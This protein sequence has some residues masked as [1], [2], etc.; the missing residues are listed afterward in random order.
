VIRDGY[1]ARWHGTDYDAVPGVDGEV[2][3]YA[4]TP[5]DGF[6]E[7]RPGRYVRIVPDH[8]VESLRYVR[9]HCTW[10]GE[11]FVVI[12]EHGDWLRLEYAGGRAPV[13]SA[14]GLDSVDVGVYQTWISREEIDQLHE[15]NI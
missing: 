13:A 15:E 8:E 2:R 11:P 12:G 3:L 7:V 1:T 5:A 9:T 4:A 10:R 6:T 14:L